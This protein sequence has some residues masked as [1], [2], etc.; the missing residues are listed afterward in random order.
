MGV[1][2]NI[3]L[4]F[5]LLVCS[6][7]TKEQITGSNLVNN[8][9][10]EEYYNCPDNS[11]ELYFCKYWWGNSTEYYNSCATVPQLSVPSNF[12]GFQYA[13]TGNAYSG[14]GIYEKSIYYT[15]Y[16][17]AIKTKLSDS[18]VAN[19][20]YCTN[21]YIAL[22]QYSYISMYN[23]ILLD[24]I[25]M[26]FTKDMVQDSIA[27]ILSAGIKA[28]NSIS[29]LDTI[30]WLHISNSFLANGG[31][32]YLTIGNFDNVINWPSGKTGMTA[33]YVDDV[34]ICECSFKLRL[35]NDTT[36]CIGQSLILNPNMPNAKYTWQDGTHDSTYKVKQAGTYWVRAYFPDYNITTYDTINVA[37]INCDTVQPIIPDIYIPNSFTPNG[38]G[39]NDVFFIKTVYEFSEFKL[40]I[41]GR[42][43]DMIFESE[44]INKGWDGTYKGKPVP[45]G[46]YIYQLTVIIKDTGEQRKITGRVTVVR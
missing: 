8:P 26:L 18:L 31:E 39:K 21:F 40:S 38:D 43:G 45:L 16:R 7:T 6:L 46:V 13:H 33:I 32:Q 35:G 20:R 11:N 22:A 19:K 29:N 23:Y 30:N 34:S 25:G 28:Q 44:D 10:F 3:L 2:K 37:Y 1:S 14:L 12:A 24:S 17:E 4:L 42:W 15:D 41:Y 27:P 9:S 5:I 36:L